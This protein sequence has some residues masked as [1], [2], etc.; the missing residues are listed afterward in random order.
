MR[1]CVCPDVALNALFETLGLFCIKTLLYLLNNS[2]WLQLLH[3]G[4]QEGDA[5]LNALPRLGNT[6]LHLKHAPNAGPVWQCQ[7]VS[8]VCVCWRQRALAH[9]LFKLQSFPNLVHV[10]R[11]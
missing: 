1:V 9:V 7:V 10:D 4:T 2:R 5:L 3:G 8:V 6:A 11:C